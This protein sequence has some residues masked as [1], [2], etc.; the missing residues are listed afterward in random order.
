M[1]YARFKGLLGM[2]ESNFYVVSPPNLAH[3]RG[4]AGQAAAAAAAAGNAASA[5]PAE[6]Q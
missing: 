3:L 5:K 6:K 2:V 1:R 4:E